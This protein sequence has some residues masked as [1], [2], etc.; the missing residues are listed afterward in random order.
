[1]TRVV[2]IDCISLSTTSTSCSPTTTLLEGPLMQY[3]H[4]SHSIS[5]PLST[6]TRS[7]SSLCSG[8][9]RSNWQIQGF[10][11]RHSLSTAHQNCI[12]SLAVFH[13]HIPATNLQW[14][15]H[16]PPSILRPSTLDTLADLF[17]RA[18]TIHV[19]PVSSHDLEVDQPIPTTEVPARTRS[20]FPWIVLAARS[21]VGTG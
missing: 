8:K 7:D 2:N 6:S 17:L 5:I 16:P 9:R 14:L 12:R 10:G 13:F 4:R 20:I 11:T 21:S 1:M 18:D 15:P 19:R 3:L